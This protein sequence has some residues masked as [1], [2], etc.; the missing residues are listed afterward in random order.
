VR[1]HARSFSWDALAEALLDL[2][3][4]LRAARAAKEG[5]P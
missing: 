2:V 5:K 4:E 1:R 3:R